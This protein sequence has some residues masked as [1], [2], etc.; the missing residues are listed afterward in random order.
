[1]KKKVK[2]VVSPTERARKRVPV[3]SSEVGTI[4]KLTKGLSKESS[5]TVEELLITIESAWDTYQRNL[6]EFNSARQVV[7]KRL[8][9]L[10]LEFATAGCKGR[11]SSALKHLSIKRSTAYELIAAY[12]RVQDLPKRVQR[13]AEKVG[14]DLSEN[15]HKG[16]VESLLN[17]E[18]MSLK[19]IEQALESGKQ[20]RPGKSVPTYA[21]D[22]SAADKAVHHGFAEITKALNNMQPTTKLEALERIVAH[23]LY[24]E[25]LN[26]VTD[27]KR[28]PSYFDELGRFVVK[29]VNAVNDWIIAPHTDK[30][31]KKSVESQEPERKVA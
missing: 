27:T 28:F 13:A 31:A 5:S 17:S 16:R 3:E 29:P 9:E 15:R 6:K 19:E 14:I 26:R 10:N 24:Y 21:P 25:V 4:E 22:T 1:M 12:E 11:F 7:G 8:H 18:G 23:Y 20:R 2:T 30:Q